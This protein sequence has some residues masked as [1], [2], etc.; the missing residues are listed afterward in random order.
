M[1]VTRSVMT[2]VS[3][4]AALAAVAALSLGM[5]SDGVRLAVT[6]GPSYEIAVVAGA[7]GRLAGSYSVTAEREGAS[8]RSRSSQGG[9]FDVGPGETD[10]LSVLRVNAASGDHVWAELVVRWPDGSSTTDR[11]EATVP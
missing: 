8:G 2:S 1:S 7:D 5:R 6:P 11:Y 9:A 4:L 3:L 10:T